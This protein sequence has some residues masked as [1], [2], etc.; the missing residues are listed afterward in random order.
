[1][2]KTECTLFFCGIKPGAR[3]ATRSVSGAPGVFVLCAQSVNPGPYK[4]N[5]ENNKTKHK[6]SVQV[7]PLNPKENQVEPWIN[8]V[9]VK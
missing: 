3:S 1:M 7:S 8:S 5:P 9:N 4:K 6:T 2:E